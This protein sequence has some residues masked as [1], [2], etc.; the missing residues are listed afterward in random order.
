LDEEKEIARRRWLACKRRQ[1]DY[2]RGLNAKVRVDEI[3]KEMDKVMR[4]LGV[5]DM[6][7]IEIFPPLSQLAP[8]EIV[9]HELTATVNQ[10]PVSPLPDPQEKPVPQSPL[11]EQ[12][13]LAV[14]P[15]KITASRKNRRCNIM[16]EG[17][18]ETA[19]IKISEK[20]CGGEVTFN[21]VNEHSFDCG[22]W[23]L[24]VHFSKTS[25]GALQMTF[26][27]WGVTVRISE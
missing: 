24:L 5:K 14:G 10:E 9:P 2:E 17:T 15:F 25:Q 1:M 27:N 26:K 6:E 23:N 21:R 16:H 8:H 22:A 12:V 20:T 4:S 18:M 11:A 7:E 3:Q 13:D 19:Y